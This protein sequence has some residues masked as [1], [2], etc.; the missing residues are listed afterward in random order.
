MIGPNILNRLT[1]FAGFGESKETSTTALIRALSQHV[2]RKLA[3][4]VLRQHDER[5]ELHIVAS[6]AVQ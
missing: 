6:E 3:L 1:A 5:A 2:H 4:H